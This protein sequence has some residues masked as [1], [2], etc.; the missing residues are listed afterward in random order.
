[1][2]AVLAVIHIEV[3]NRFFFCFDAL[4]A[5]PHI[6][7]GFRPEIGIYYVAQFEVLPN[8]LALSTFPD[9]RTISL[10]FVVT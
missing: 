5:T 8:P 3:S 7:E 4:L 1:M 2:S 6:S 10:Y 9:R